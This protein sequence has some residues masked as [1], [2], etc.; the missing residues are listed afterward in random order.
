MASLFDRYQKEKRQKKKAESQRKARS[1]ETSIPM[2]SVEQ[3]VLIERLSHEGR[4]IA[5]DAHGKT[6]FV[7]GALPSEHVTFQVTQT[8]SRFNEAHAVSILKAAPTRQ[9]P[10]CTHYGTCGG[11][12]M[13]HATTSLQVQHKESVIREQLAHFANIS[14]DA[15]ETARNKPLVG[16]SYSY[17]R[18]ARLGVTKTKSQGLVLG[19]REYQSKRLTPIYAC[20]ILVPTLSALLE[21]LQI[22]LKKLKGA[23]NIGHIELIQGEDRNLVVVRMVT[24]MSEADRAL[25]TDFETQQETSVIIATGMDRASEYGLE[26]KTL[27]NEPCPELTYSLDIAGHPIHL[28]FGP[29]DFLQVNADINQKMVEQALAWL[30]LEKHEHVLELFCGFGNFSLPLALHAGSVTAIEVSQQQVNRGTENAAHNGINNLTFMTANLEEPLAKVALPPH[31]MDVVLLDPPRTGAEKVCEQIS[32]INPK[33][34]LYVS[35]NPATL[36]RDT[37]ILERQGYALSKWGMLDMFPQTAHAECM[38][39]FERR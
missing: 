2:Q 17:R 25:W 27:H 5:N 29:N 30:Q 13:Q 22:V 23:G 38:V 39:L 16:D 1:T 18:K 15:I 11:C 10:R 28:A 32:L 36:A 7:R 4:G 19:F 20:P 3:G 24:A 31:P 9:D 33:R 21:P 35:C 8:H 37:Q 26:F 34:I 6:I 12:S 14:D